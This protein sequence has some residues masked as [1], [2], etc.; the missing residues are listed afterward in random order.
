MTS[1]G[2]SCRAYPD[3]PRVG[4]GAVVFRGDRV[5]L[6]QRG[7]PP[8][9]GAW[10]LPGGLQDLGE[11]VHD[12]A[13]REVAEETGVTIRMLGLVDVIDAIDREPD[14]GRIRYHYTIVDVAA[15]WCHGEGEAC[16]DAAAV[17]WLPLVQLDTV[18]L[19]GETARVIRLARA[20]WPEATASS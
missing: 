5:L 6:I 20:R 2:E 17:R 18:P 13:V 8:A 7:R 10:T 15:L 16:D 12:A 4:V 11:T 9:K 14:T 19:F 3:L 1:E